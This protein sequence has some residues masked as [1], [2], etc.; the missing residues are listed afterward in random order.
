M[1]IEL[2]LSYDANGLFCVTHSHNPTRY[3]HIAGL[4][5]RF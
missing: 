3:S 4:S 5:S 1:W 2:L